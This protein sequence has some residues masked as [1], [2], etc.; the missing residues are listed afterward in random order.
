LIFL[1]RNSYLP[2]IRSDSGYQFALNGAQAPFANKSITYFSPVYDAGSEPNDENCDNIPRPVCGGIGGSPDEGGEGYV[3]I[4]SGI[5]GTDG[6][7]DAATYDWRN[8]AAKITIKRVRHTR[9]IQFY[10][11]HCPLPTANRPLPTANC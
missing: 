10:T 4:H 7:L 11:A 6:D 8:P 5:H 3:H 2:T 1:K 9:L